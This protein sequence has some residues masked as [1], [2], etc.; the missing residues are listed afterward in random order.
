MAVMK[1]ESRLPAGFAPE[2]LGQAAIQTTRYREAIPELGELDPTVVSF[3][4]VSYLTSPITKDSLNHYVLFVPN[5]D[6]ARRIDRYQWEIHRS[7]DAGVVPIP[8]SSVSSKEGVFEYR[9]TEIGE[10]TILVRLLASGG[11][12]L[13][14]VQM[15]QAVVPFSEEFEA[16]VKKLSTTI[17]RGWW[18]DR[19]P[20]IQIGSAKFTNELANDLYRYIQDSV[21]QPID[22]QPNQIPWQLLAAVA[23]R[24]MFFSPKENI[25]GTRWHKFHRTSE[26]SQYRNYLND[27]SW[28]LLDLEGWSLGVCQMQP[29]TLATALVNPVTQR[30][31]T[32]FLEE[33]PAR[34]EG[35]LL[36]DQRLAAYLALDLEERVDLY[37]LLRFPRSHLRMCNVYLQKL[38]DRTHRLPQL[39]DEQVLGMK[40]VPTEVPSSA[41][42]A[43]DPGLAIQIIAT[44][45]NRGPTT[46]GWGTV[47]TNSYGREVHTIVTSPMMNALTSLS[48]LVTDVWGVVVGNNGAP[49]ANARVDICQTILTPESGLKCWKRKEDFKDP[50]A[51]FVRLA[52]GTGYPVLELERDHSHGS[53]ALDLVKVRVA[54]SLWDRDEGW[55]IARDGRTYYAG[56]SA[57]VSRDVARTDD[58]GKFKVVHPDRAPLKLRFVKEADA[59]G[60][61]FFDGESTWGTSPSYHKVVLQAADHMVREADIV[62][63]LPDWEAYVYSQ[64]WAANYPDHY[65]LTKR[66]LGLVEASGKEIACNS[67]TQALI[68]EAWARRYPQLE[69]SAKNWRGFILYKDPDTGFDPFGPMTESLRGDG[70]IT[71]AVAVDLSDSD[72]S[73]PKPPPRW[74]LVQGWATWQPGEGGGAGH[75]FIIVDHHRS[76]DKVLTLEANRGYGLDGVG[77]RHIGNVASEKVAGRIT[78]NR[79]RVWVE[80]ANVKSWKDLKAAYGALK[81]STHTPNGRENPVGIVR[82][83]VY[84]LQ[85]SGADILESAVLLP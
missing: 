16:M 36:S 78:P 82:L 51:V 15:R 14:T 60:N 69:W 66:G 33:D 11:Q 17:A 61:G 24:E 38:K 65:Y 57:Q 75:S 25:T 40:A 83:K 37:N 8:V 1:T 32:E 58:K 28:G 7:L 53:Q 9:P 3:A 42:L 73:P 55:V 68:T 76:S 29:Q 34:G 48:N 6:L 39:D 21:A 23:Y 10:L 59:S 43:R 52:A 71:M 70:K 13:G 47:E 46:T 72:L 64:A 56:L 12:V 80:K 50:A 4:L 18:S 19:Q 79:D 2:Q 77:M 31:Y 45:Y 85:W 49:V 30:P 41:R 5:N 81:D 22:G 27:T 63:L 26:L 35:A 20:D 84:D 54:T 74:S 44:E 62:A 67:F